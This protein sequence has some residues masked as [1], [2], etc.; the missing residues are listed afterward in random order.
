MKKI[1]E[2]DF[3]YG[4]AA[5]YLHS[6]S[7]KQMFSNIFVR[8]RKLDN[9]MREDTYFLIGDKGTGKTAYAVFLSNN[10]YKNTESEVVN[11]EST[12]YKVFMNLRDS[13][14]INLS[15]YARVWKI[16]LL[17]LVAKMIDKK[18]IQAFGP[19]RSK[20]FETLQENI[21]NYYDGAF[22]PE[23]ATSLKYIVDTAS[24]VNTE[25]AWTGNA[26]NGG[27]STKATVQEKSEEVIQK[28]QNNLLDME[29]GFSDAFKRLKIRKSK[30]LFIDS[31]DIK[32]SDITDNEYKLCLEGLANA[33][34]QVNTGV[35]RS[36]PVSDGFLKVVLSIRTDMFPQLNLHNQANK[37]RDNSVVL[38]W[39]TTY[40]N[41]RNSPLFKLCNN[42][43]AYENPGLEADQYWDYYFPWCTE[44]T[45]IQKRDKDDSFI[46]CLRLSLSRPRDFISIMKAIQ[47]RDYQDKETSSVE[48]FQD[49]ETQ[50]AISNYYV[51]EARDWCLHKF[52]DEAFNTLMYF[53]QFLNGKSRFTYEEYTEFYNNF[54]EQVSNRNLEIFDE[55][56]ES[57]KFLQLLYD[58]NMICYY[59]VAPN[60]GEF[61]RFCYREREIHNL[62]PKI[63]LQSKYGIHYALLKALNLGKKSIPDFDE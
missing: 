41:Y 36:M 8:D 38:D 1:S 19:K 34:W 20:L 11:I 27:V 26:A 48:W 35:F 51:D 9:L 31:V 13:G 53:F 16:I 46:N 37:I 4:D 3:G 23:V 42:L 12:D 33:I 62:E 29:R 14:Y 63:K 25:L 5:N 49:N 60:G 55:L 59:D 17:M 15:D 32:L 7:Y 30:F 22:I 24:G 6:R 45:N 40:E 18:D 2:L 50:N 52:S 54:I 10:E 21:D 43:L 47:D 58:L 56:L 61:F 28:F 57:D 44:S 39:R